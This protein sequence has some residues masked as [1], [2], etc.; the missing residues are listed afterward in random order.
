M[1]QEAKHTQGPW[2][3][4]QS[5]TIM[6]NAICITASQDG[7]KTYGGHI[8]TT[9]CDPS[10]YKKCTNFSPEE[11][12]ANARL[13]AASPALLQAAAQA[14]KAIESFKGQMTDEIAAEIA[15]AKWSLQAA[16]AEALAA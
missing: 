11:Q 15:N 4:R 3:I 8:V 16:I 10:S 9:L 5:A 7:G 13:I 1:M 14:V 2:G 6:E 12:V